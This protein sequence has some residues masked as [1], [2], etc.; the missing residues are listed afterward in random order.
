MKKFFFLLL[1]CLIFLPILSIDLVSADDGGNPYYSVETFSLENGT[2][3]NEVIINGPPAPPVG[4]ENA[5]KKSIVDLS[6]SNMIMS[7][8]TLVVPAYDWS[9]GCSATSGAMI[10]AYYDRNGFPN[11]YSGPTNSG[12]M[13]LNSSSW[14]SWT[15]G[16]G[17]TYGQCPL[18]ASRLELDGRTTRGSI[19][20]Y[21]VSYESSSSDPYITNSWSQ[22]TWG[23]AIGDYMKTCQSAYSNVD[24]S[25]TFYTYTSSPSQLTCSN[26]EIY[27]IAP[28]DGTYGRKLFYEARGYSVS[29]CYNQKTSNNGGSFTY[30]TFK[31]E[32]DAGYP[33]MINLAGHTVVGVGYSDP[34]TIYIHDTWDYNTHSM[35]WGSSY[36]GLAMQ[37]VSVVHLNSSGGVLNGSVSDAESSAPIVG[38]TIKAATSYQTTSDASGDY[39]LTLPIGVYT[40]TTAATGYITRTITNIAI[41]EGITTTQNVSLAREPAALSYSPTSLETE[42][43]LGKNSTIPLTLTVDT[44]YSITFELQEESPGIA[45]LSENPVNGSL[46]L[47]QSQVVNVS[48]DAA[49]VAEGGEYTGTLHLLSDDASAP[50]QS[51]P[52]LMNVIDSTPTPTLTPTN[53]PTGTATRTPS[54]DETDTPTM[55][56]TNTHTPTSNRTSTA[57]RTPT[58]TR[59][60]TITLTQT[61]SYTLS[62]TPTNTTS[63]TQ[64]HTPTKTQTKINTPTTTPTICRTPLEYGGCD[65][66]FPTQTLTHTP[67]QTKTQTPTQTPTSTLTRTTT[68]TPTRTLTNIP[69]LTLSPTSTQTRT[70]TPRHNQILYLPFIFR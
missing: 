42:I 68:T 36:A 6:K 40:I 10:A 25:T 23:E 55:T 13:P 65:P 31:S 19:D 16:N 38:A 24:G 7:A 63:A 37:S 45:W 41:E 27:E 12:V 4:Y 26:M 53:T 50:D 51:I 69:T 30:T 48:F 15:D 62:Q 21:W 43:Q 70:I 29:T 2:F 18:T 52:V 14:G 60:P 64:T 8:H 1:T 20:D 49:A 39:S 32:I 11:M 34:S 22:H 57:T 47:S 66:I 33:V 28:Y 35:T 9:F 5:V 59:S 46:S 44:P 54:G 61:L 67:T 56:P 17:D 3:I 58:P